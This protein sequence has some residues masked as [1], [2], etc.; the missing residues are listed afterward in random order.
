MVGMVI[1]Q[2]KKVRPRLASF[3]VSSHSGTIL[4][5]R[6]FLTSSHALSRVEGAA[7][8]RFQR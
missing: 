4:E 5:A 2:P 6:C 8:E 1:P 7:A 3:C